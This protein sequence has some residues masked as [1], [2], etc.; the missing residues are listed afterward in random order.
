[1]AFTQKGECRNTG[2]THFRKGCTPWNKG[3]TGIYS[4]EQLKRIS[5]TTKARLSVS[6]PMKGKH[7]SKESI[8][9]IREARARQINKPSNKGKPWSDARRKAQEL[10]KR[11]P[12]KKRIIIPKKVIRNGREYHPAWNEIRKVIYKRDR[13]LCQCCGVH[14]RNKIRISCHH[15]DYDIANNDP[16]NLITLCISCHAKTNFKRI[17]WIMFFNKTIGA[18]HLTTKV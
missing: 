10:V 9:K 17:D 16:N 18:S 5:E 6:H 3:K 7:H 15:I 12:N 8:E 4:N 13:W 11:S 2:K 14:C 1:M